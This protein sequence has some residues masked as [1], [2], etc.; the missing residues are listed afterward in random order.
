MPCLD[1]DTVAAYL[2]RDLAPDERAA[3][4]AHL[5]ECEDCRQ[6]IA[7][8]AWL[9]TAEAE[10]DRPDP[11]AEVR[12]DPLDPAAGDIA[13][14]AGVAEPTSDAMIHI[15][16][17]I[18]RYVVLREL[19]VG[20]FGVV[21]L[22][23]DPKLD[24]RIALKVVP[25]VHLGIGNEERILREAQA[26]AR[27]SHPNVTAVY[28]VTTWQSRACIA[29]ELIDGTDARTWLKT[30]RE[31]TEILDAFMQAGRGLAAAHEA[32]LVH[33]DFK[34]ANMLIG[35]DGRTSVTDFGLAR[36]RAEAPHSAGSPTGSSAGSSG[37]SSAGSSGGSPPH[38]VA[39]PTTAL[40]TSLTA[41][42]VMVGTPRYMAPEQHRGDRATARS[43][44]FSFCLALAEALCGR[45]PFDFDEPRELPRAVLKGSLRTAELR[46]LPGWI[47][48]PLLRG[49]STDPQA[50]YPT[51]EPLLT[52]LSPQR[53]LRRRRR[54]QTAA[55]GLL[56]ATLPAAWVYGSRRA[57]S[58]AC[59]GGRAK[60][61]E[62]FGPERQAALARIFEESALPYA[63][64]SWQ[65][66]RTSVEQ[67]LDTWNSQYTEACQATRRG[68]QSAEVLTARMLCL[69]N[70]RDEIRYVLDGL[71]V[72]GDRRVRGAVQ[73]VQ[74]LRDLEVCAD[75]ES[76]LGQV[77]VGE[78]QR[79]RV[80]GVRASLTRA[81][82]RAIAGDGET[83]RSL[84]DEAVIGAREVG[85]APTLAEALLQLGRSLVMRGELDAA[86]PALREAI[87]EANHG[88]HDRAAAEA[89]VDLLFVT[90]SLSHRP[91]HELALA[92]QAALAR[93][94]GHRPLHARH[95]AAQGLIH[96][97]HGRYEQAL[98][99][100]RRALE[101]LEAEHG[102][103]AAAVG[104]QLHRVAEVLVEVAEID[105][106]EALAER[107]AAILAQTY[108]Q[109][110]PRVA[111][112]LTVLARCA[113]ARAEYSRCVELAERAVK[114]RVGEHGVL[115]AAVLPIMLVHAEGLAGV[116]R[117][118][119]A[120]A[121]LT[122][123]RRLAVERHGPRSLW[124]GLTGVALARAL[125]ER[126][127]IV[128]ARSL[129]DEAIEV[130]EEHHGPDHPD[131]VVARE[132][133]A[134]VA[135]GPR[136]PAVEIGVSGSL[137]AKFAG[138]KKK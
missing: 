92:S 120:F 93:V 12:P 8:I 6:L 108:G 63:A 78:Q 48:Q 40:E 18:G 35:H 26:M 117:H 59:T 51:M 39:M 137:E 83:S 81:R 94:R 109:E 129:L 4:E 20:G 66:T 7:E 125:Y 45:H 119:D 23:Y 85:H 104:V 58:D 27:L 99:D 136:E 90:G 138:S 134:R 21:L 5:A 52:A 30:P 56:L 98:T 50:R 79:L 106:A 9:S 133:R 80:A 43:D 124:A 37:G 76:L 34:P 102:L 38:G 107:S 67:W 11:A 132:Q 100:Q 114:I 82:A 71:A 105:Q 112:P 16:S 121:A 74:S 75:V 32:G 2:R 29:M 64:T 54:R 13:E 24:R 42:G 47:R 10:G 101:L 72:A 135:V 57:D 17:T 131:V 53:R 49:L 115:E 70:A 73:S 127:Q 1:D 126:R 96:A 61:E 19:G 88:R 89:W 123:A 113:C 91:L 68:E 118:E 33:R 15:G 130:L 25:L 14:S 41:A 111:L 110:H 28:D 60:V 44:Q 86:E 97:Q 31:R 77:P 116:G 103:D 65:T 122:A 84:S 128:E 87:L 36:L 3:A 46:R 22:A 62:I 55:A 69:D 95:A